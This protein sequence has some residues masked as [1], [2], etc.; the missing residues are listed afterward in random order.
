[1]GINFQDTIDAYVD[2]ISAYI[3]A[4]DLKNAIAETDYCYSSQAATTLTF[5]LYSLYRA[6][7]LY[8]R[9]AWQKEIT[10]DTHAKQVLLE[11]LEDSGGNDKQSFKWGI[12][13]QLAN[14]VSHPTDR[15]K[16]EL[17]YPLL[18]NNRVN[19]YTDADVE[20]LITDLKQV[21]KSGSR[22]E[23]K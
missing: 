10:D 16:N 15:E 17:L 12:L 2:I 21:L 18:N 14:S 1:M 8:S 3:T 23:L 19:E 7:K 4:E 13:L 6:A 22:Q 9:S 20:N 11:I 5:G